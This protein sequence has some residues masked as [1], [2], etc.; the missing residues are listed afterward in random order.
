MEMHSDLELRYYRVTNF[1]IVM[2]HLENGKDFARTGLEY[3]DESQTFVLR[4]TLHCLQPDLEMTA[5][6]ASFEIQEQNRVV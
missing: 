3:Q 1:Q 6:L 5:D 4:Q 2:V